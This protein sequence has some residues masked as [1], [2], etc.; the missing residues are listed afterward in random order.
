MYCQRPEK[1]KGKKD[2]F[3]KKK[4]GKQSAM[5]LGRE[6]EKEFHYL[7]E[8]GGRGGKYL[9]FFLWEKERPFPGRTKKDAAQFRKKGGGEFAVKKKKKGREKKKKEGTGGGPRRV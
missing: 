5:T 8:G 7:T 2:T 9:V 4:E 3:L 6:K 1:R